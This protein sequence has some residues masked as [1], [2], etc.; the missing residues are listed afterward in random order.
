[1]I[2]AGN[3]INDQAIS[4]P[5]PSAL[6]NRFIHYRI[7]EDYQSFKIWADGKI[8][9]LILEFLD[10]YPHEFVSKQL[11]TD[12]NIIITPRSWEILSKL[13]H[14]ADHEDYEWV[15][16]SV[17]GKRI[18]KLMLSRE[19]SNI[20]SILDGSLNEIPEDIAHIHMLCEDLDKVVPK[21]IHDD[22]ATN[23]LIGFLNQIPLDYAIPVF[24]TLLQ[25]STEAYEVEE[26]ENYQRFIEK[27]ERLNQ[28]DA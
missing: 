12:S 15:I 4:H 23:H 27:L 14:H 5:M 6:K 3:G 19:S 13:L 21:I 2:A 18:A 9:P 11:D 10:T 16:A 22:K 20:Q 1:M 7:V 24:R 17:V 26:L 8:H 25:T 28:E